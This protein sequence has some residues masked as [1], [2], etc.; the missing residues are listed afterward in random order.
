MR[1]HTQSKRRSRLRELANEFI[2]M[3]SSAAE[4]IAAYF[5][6][7]YAAYE[8]GNEYIGGWVACTYS[9]DFNYLYPRVTLTDAKLKAVENANDSVFPEI[10]AWIEN[11]D[12]GGRWD[13]TYSV[14]WH[15]AHV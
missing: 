12:S 2:V 9:G 7:G 15:A 14:D 13:A 10:P 1:D 8:G 4:D 11:L 3:D 5:P 6:E